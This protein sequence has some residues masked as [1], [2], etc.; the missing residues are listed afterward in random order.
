MGSCFITFFPHQVDKLKAEYK[1]TEPRRQYAVNTK[2]YAEKRQNQNEKGQRNSTKQMSH[3]EIAGTAERIEEKLKARGS[4]L[5][6][7]GEREKAPQNKCLT[8]R[9]QGPQRQERV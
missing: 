6:E 7:K 9:S 1:E 3:T 4:R 5:K 8:Q 2:E